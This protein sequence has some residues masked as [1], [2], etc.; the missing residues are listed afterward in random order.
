[1]C[2]A[3]WRKSLYGREGKCS[4]VSLQDVLAPVHSATK[5][6]AVQML[7]QLRTLPVDEQLRALHTMCEPS[8]LRC[9]FYVLRTYS[10][11]L[12][13]SKRREQCERT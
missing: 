3:D 11:K 2:P 7:F 6:H 13:K 10:S 1:M 5:L 9:V 8:T 4:N 12:Q